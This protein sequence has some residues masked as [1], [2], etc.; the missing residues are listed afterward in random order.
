MKITAVETI[1][2]GT[3]WRE[4]TFVEL[5]S[6]DGLRGPGVALHKEARAAHPRTNAHFTPVRDGWERRD[7]ADVEAVRS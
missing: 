3:P 4:P 7:G 2:V 6:D 5:I 1:L